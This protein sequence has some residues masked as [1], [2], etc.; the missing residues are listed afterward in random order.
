MDIGESVALLLV[1]FDMYSS[2]LASGNMGFGGSGN[3]RPC[4]PNAVGLKEDSSSTTTRSSSLRWP[5]K[6]DEN[7]DGTRTSL[8]GKRN[9]P[10]RFLSPFSL[11]KTTLKLHNRFVWVFF[12]FSSQGANGQKAF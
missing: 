4:M 3:P 12:T 2:L 7:R 5:S 10:L 9:N 1:D 8:I 6:E 11:C